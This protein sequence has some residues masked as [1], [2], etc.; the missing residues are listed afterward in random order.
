MNP[1]LLI[2]IY[3]HPDTIY[4][5][6]SGLSPLGLPCIIVD[7]GSGEAT[8][9]A[10]EQVREAFDFVEVVTRERNGGRGAALKTGY[11]HLLSRGYT[12]A[13]QLAADDQHDATDAPAFLKAAAEH[14]TALVLGDPI[15]DDTAPRSRFYGRFISRFWV[16]VETW[17]RDIHDPLC[18]MRC[19]PL[20]AT[21]RVLDETETGD[22]M[23]FDPEIA[24]RLVWAGVPVVN[25]PTRVRYF[26][27][28]ISHFDLVRDNV[29]ISKAHTRLFF[30]MLALAPRLL[31]R[32]LGG[33][34]DS[35][36]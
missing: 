5:V 22:Y 2:T 3:D 18:G 33:S 31:R 1:C 19:M 16:W 14:P 13:L 26:E 35:A 29:R 23:E 8:V 17:S 7:D 36:T 25:V 20:E 10:L 24:V 34:N 15:F 30:E 9:K 6:V 4:D 21:V 11:R 32:K 12:H 28:G 27:E